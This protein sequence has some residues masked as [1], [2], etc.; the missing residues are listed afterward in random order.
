M[1]KERIWNV[2][3]LLVVRY[4]SKK[5]KLQ[6]SEWR[7]DNNDEFIQFSNWI[8]KSVTYKLNP[9]VIESSNKKHKWVGAQFYHGEIFAVPNDETRVLHYDTNVNYIEN[10]RSGLFK[11]TGGC[12]WNDAIY[13]FPRTASSF[14]KINGN[15]I[16]EIP[17]TIEYGEEHHYS[18]VCTKDGIV[19]QPPRN[20]NH[21]LKTDL[22][23]GISTKIDI[24]DEKYNIFFRYC[25]SIIHPNGLIYF[26]PERNNQVIRL[27]PNTDKWDFI[28]K[29]VSTMCFDAKIGIDGNIYGFSAYNRGVMKIDVIH[30]TVQMLHEEISPGAYGTKYGVDGCLYSV[31]GDGNAIYKYNIENNKIEVFF[32][33]NDK[34]KAKY[35]GGC[36]RIN[37]TIVC[38]SATENSILCLAPDKELDIPKEIFDFFFV[39]CY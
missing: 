36:T 16:K 28:G 2:Y 7:I 19:Y 20:T 4:L 26:F 24:V 32:N 29:K 37:G 3:N 30:N 25:G 5:S 31:P 10:I 23:T 27:D 18:G 35:A 33:L 39:D 22:K 13:C 14:L 11:W 38:I 15:N 9:I 8:D 17:L 21:I 1:I 34:S 12:V 6:T